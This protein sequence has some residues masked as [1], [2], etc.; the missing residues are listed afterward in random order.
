MSTWR[1]PFT[2]RLL[3]GLLIAA[4]AWALM[5]AHAQAHGDAAHPDGAAT[6][7]QALAVD[8]H[9]AGSGLPCGPQAACAPTFVL[10]PVAA[11]A[12][13]APWRLLQVRGWDDRRT[14][15]HR[16]AHEPPPPR[17]SA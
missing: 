6:L 7:V 1:R 9:E 2:L 17:H 16:H 11:A 3:A 14:H 15:L 10:Q 5:P 12:F 8:S 13:V 4:L